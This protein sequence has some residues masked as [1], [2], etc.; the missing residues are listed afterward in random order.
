MLYILY[1]YIYN[2]V[3]LNDTHVSTYTLYV[4]HFGIMRQFFV[5]IY[6]LYRLYRTIVLKKNTTYK[7]HFWLSVNNT[8]G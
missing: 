5:I 8:I 2:S 3:D 1:I 4:L 6:N 7:A